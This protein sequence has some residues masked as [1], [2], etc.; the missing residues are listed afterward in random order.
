MP[1][2]IDKE[3][4]SNSHLVVW[5]ITESLDELISMVNTEDLR[6]INERFVNNKKL[7]TLATRLCVAHLCNISQQGY[8]GIK[9]DDWG[10]PHL[11]KSNAHISIAHSFPYA[12]ATI[13]LSEPTGIDV[14]QRREQLLRIKHKF[15]SNSELE[16]CKDDLDLLTQA[17][18]AKEVLY[19]IHGRKKLSFKYELPIKIY[20][21][22]VF[23]R[24]LE[25]SSFADHELKIDR[26][27]DYWLVYKS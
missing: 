3:V 17:W 16:F 23:G 10:K 22:K 20:K 15:L 7:E 8:Y 11:I 27:A 14:E 5:H 25:G 1:I 26:I 4:N 24:I 13:N 18:C 19:K 2:I 9:K 6:A 12:V 21:N